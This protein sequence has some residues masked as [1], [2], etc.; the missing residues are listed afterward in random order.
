MARL[1][2]HRPRNA[3]TGIDEAKNMYFDP[4]PDLEGWFLGLAE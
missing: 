2:S 3:M 4:S 1:E